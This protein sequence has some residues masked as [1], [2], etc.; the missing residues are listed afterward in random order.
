V[1]LE[2]VCDPEVPRLP[3]H[4]RVDQAKGP[5]SALRQGEP[6]SRD[7][8]KNAIKASSTNSRRAQRPGD[9]RRGARSGAGPVLPCTG[10]WSLIRL[11]G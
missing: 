3:P 10:P 4:I 6:A 11:G 8:I 9:L 1:V 2:V 5:A 7:I